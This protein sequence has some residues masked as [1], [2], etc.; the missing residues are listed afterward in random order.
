MTIRERAR[1]DEPGFE[2][3]AIKRKISTNQAYRGR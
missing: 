1:A 2:S 3:E